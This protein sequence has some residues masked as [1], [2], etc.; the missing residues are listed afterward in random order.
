MLMSTAGRGRLGARRVR[1][2]L[3]WQACLWTGK[4]RISATT[5]ETSVSNELLHIVHERD[6]GRNI[7][8]KAGRRSDLLNRA[9]PHRG[10]VPI[11]D[12][13]GAA[14]ARIGCAVYTGDGEEDGGDGRGGCG[15]VWNILIHCV[16]A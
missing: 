10:V 4:A 15:D 11:M 14:G 13:R 2:R 8:D 9:V 7:A 16:N 1:L 5:T 6:R 12:K 3:G